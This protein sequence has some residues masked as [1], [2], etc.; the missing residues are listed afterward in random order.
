MKTIGFAGGAAH[1][2]SLIARFVIVVLVVALS[3]AAARAAVAQVEYVIAISVDGLRPDAITTLGPADAP[4]F[5]RLRNEGAFTDNARTDYDYSNTL[6]NHTSMLTGRRVTTS[7]SHGYTQ[8]DDPPANQ[9]IHSNKGS[10][11]ASVFDVAHDN[12]L[13][14]ALYSGKTKFVLY[15]RS[16]NSTNGALD[17]TGPDD[18]RNKIDRTIIN[19]DSE[20]L[21]ASFIT[22]LENLPY[23]FSMLHLREPDDGAVSRT[24]LRAAPRWVCCSRWWP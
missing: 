4:N 20:A 15:P 12:G 14:T 11:V 23:N 8:N 24:A 18:G 3:V 22:G 13:R 1:N 17:V 7:A 16:Y 19:V 21:T 6:P 2:N 5:Y 10:Y 9:T